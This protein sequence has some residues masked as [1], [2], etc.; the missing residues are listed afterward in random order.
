MSETCGH[1]G[2]DLRLL[3]S[4]KLCA[5]FVPGL[6]VADSSSVQIDIDRNG[7]MYGTVSSPR[8]AYRGTYIRN[9]VL[10][11]DNDD[12]VVVNYAKF[13]DILAKIK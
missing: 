9:A 7:I 11:F 10:S 12:G 4:R 3:D 6:Y 1:Y 8:V 2:L 5:F 13:G